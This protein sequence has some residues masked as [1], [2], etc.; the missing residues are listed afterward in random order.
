MTIANQKICIPDAVP[1]SQNSV[2]LKMK[3]GVRVTG[4]S[5]IRELSNVSINLAVPA[6]IQPPP[7]KKASTI[8]CVKGKITK[9]VTAVSPKCPQGY[10]KK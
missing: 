6:K 9:K 7:A 1:G 5:D 2:L 4:A 10:K 8:T 3:A